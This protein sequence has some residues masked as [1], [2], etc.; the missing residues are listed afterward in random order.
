MAEVEK[1]KPEIKLIVS[2]AHVRPI[3]V[4]SYEAVG[5][6]VVT[7]PHRDREEGKVLV[8]RVYR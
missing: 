5:W 7:D 6:S 4:P 1:P 2:N 8:Q 3:D